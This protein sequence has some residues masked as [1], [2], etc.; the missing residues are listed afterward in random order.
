MAR[1]N[2]DDVRDNKM[3]YDQKASDQIFSVGDAVYYK[4]HI[5]KKGH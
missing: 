3:R 4:N 1:E 2:L 5:I